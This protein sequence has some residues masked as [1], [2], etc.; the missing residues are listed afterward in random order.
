M[1]EGRT[2]GPQC[3][4]LQGRFCDLRLMEFGSDFCI[5]GYIKEALYP[6]SL[7]LR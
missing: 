2:L 4:Y 1:M 3:H 5:P 7:S 6:K